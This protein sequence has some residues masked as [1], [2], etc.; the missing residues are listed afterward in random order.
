MEFWRFI[1]SDANLGPILSGTHDPLLVTLSIAV[2]C[3]A[4]YA[5]LSVVDRI[6]AANSANA[7][8]GWLA[9][10]GFAM[11]SGIWAMHFTA[12]TA[13]SIDMPVSYNL[14]LTLIS[15]LPSILG[16]CICLHFM[17]RLSI[18]WWHLQLGGLLMAI[19]IGT[20][21]Y[22]GMEAMNMPGQLRYDPVLFVLSIVMA[23]VLATASLYM[24]FIPDR[25]AQ[26]Q[27]LWAKVPS[28]VVMGHAVA[29]MHYIAMAA[30]QFVDD[31]TA[32]TTGTHLSP[33]ILGVSICMITSLIMGITIIG[34]IVDR[35]LEEAAVLLHKSETWAD[36]ILNT[37]TDAIISMD[38]NGKI[39]SFNQAA[40]KIFGYTPAEVLGRN[41]TKLMP[42]P[43][44]ENHHD[45][46]ARYLQT[47]K[48]RIMA[49]YRE[50]T[51]RRKDGTIFPAELGV[52]ELARDNGLV[53][54]GTLRD[55]AERKTIE[56]QL[57]Q[58]QKLESI[59]QLAAGIAHEINTPIQFIGDNARFLEDAFGNMKPL[60]ETWGRVIE[61]A[62]NGNPD[63]E[64]LDKARTVAEQVDLPYLNEEIPAAIR[65]SLEGIG[66]V[67]KIVMAMKEFSHPGN[68]D[69]QYVN[70]N[71]A[72]DSTITVSRNE[73]KYV[74]DLETE[75]D[76]N[77]PLVPCMVGEFNQVML[78][79]IVNAAHAIADN[80]K[81]NPAAKG[82]IKIVT[83]HRNPWVEIGI[84]DTG[85]GI[86]KDIQGKIFDPFFTTKELGK[87][88]GQGLAIAY[89]CITKKHGG[90][91][92]FETEMGKGTSF[93]IRLPIAADEK[94]D[95]GE[96]EHLLNG[97]PTPVPRT[98]SA[99]TLRCATDRTQ[100]S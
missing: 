80:K 73:W 3:L 38:Q 5:A 4:G 31:P 28:S 100:L 95:L 45:Y 74:A 19:G 57:S 94:E 91:I 25:N 16:S 46:L 52:N 83:C 92:E 77:L 99:A 58:A 13:F 15:M 84:S 88:T 21:H 23:H 26:A 53:F 24:K 41:I 33:F 14:A 60:I 34:T 30:A 20:M 49:V 18:G 87:G 66:R 70:I 76:Q 50:V 2:A 12:M 65:Q 43:Y 82:K 39:L 7:K 9:A 64:L 81:S 11:G 79:L 48:S 51:A 29:A 56:A 69:K 61:A 86:S 54:I 98:Q 40:I 32:Y 59:G 62:G 90:T 72:I 89:S 42:A 17:S 97:E 8:R 37:A 55:I 35:R 78:N 93:I 44:S 27:T 36:A 85:T 1:S 96:E 10:G 22:I 67:S 68:K 6:I 47:G 63:P 75:F 71:H